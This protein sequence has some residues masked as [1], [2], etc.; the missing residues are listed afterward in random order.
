MNN[1]ANST[2]QFTRASSSRASLSDQPTKLSCFRP[3]SLAFF[4]QAS[5]ENNILRPL[6]KGNKYP[7]SPRRKSNY[8]NNFVHTTRSPDSSRNEPYLMNQQT[9]I[10]LLNFATYGRNRKITL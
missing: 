10:L 4:K 1:Q 8:G 7:A 6:T 2:L 3:T 5:I 9:K